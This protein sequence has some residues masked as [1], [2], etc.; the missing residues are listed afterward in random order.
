[1]SQRRHVGSHTVLIIAS[2]VFIG[3]LLVVVNVALKTRR[4]YLRE[5]L[6]LPADP[7]WSNFTSAWDRADMATNLRNSVLYAVCVGVGTAVLALFAAYP[8]ARRHIRGA[9]ML[10]AMFVVGLFLPTSLVAIVLLME[11]LGLTNSRA[12]YVVL[13]VSRSICF[14]VFLLVG[15]VRSVP[16]ELDDAAAMDGCGYA[17]YVVRILLPLARPALLTVALLSAIGTWNDFLNPFLFLTDPE[18][19]P[20]SSGL[21]QFFGSYSTDWPVLAAGL[22]LTIMPVMVAFVV[23]QRFII[24]GVMRGALKG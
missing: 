10:H 3:P 21:F 13:S 17:R 16:R 2:L 8:I 7:Q 6:T 12:G 1:M 23:L 15:F 20:V 22:V 4:D 19:R 11:R 14:A 9:G 24:A 5:P 18:K